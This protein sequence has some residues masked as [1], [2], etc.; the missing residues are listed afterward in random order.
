M[1]KSDIRR[2]RQ[3]MALNAS[4]YQSAT[5]LAEGAAA[6]LDLSEELDDPLSPIWELAL[7][8]LETEHGS[9]HPE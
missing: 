8:Y 9:Y 2:V 3:H 5:E 4:G 6:E 1:T 7:L